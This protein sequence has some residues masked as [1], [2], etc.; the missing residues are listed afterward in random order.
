MSMRAV[1]A[2]SFVAFV[3]SRRQLVEIQGIGVA[4]L[5]FRQILPQAAV[6]CN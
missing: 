3:S 1:L 6:L 5:T 4:G 2:G